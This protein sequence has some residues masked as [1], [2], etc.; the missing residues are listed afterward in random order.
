MANGESKQSDLH[1]G[2]SGLGEDEKKTLVVLR[3]RGSMLLLGWRIFWRV[4]GGLY[5]KKATK[6]ER[7]REKR[8]T[9][10]QGI[11]MK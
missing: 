1:S 5:S 4:E 11:M 3:K 7:I 6:R 2:K 8:E 9:W 10:P